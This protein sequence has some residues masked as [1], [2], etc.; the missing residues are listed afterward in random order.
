[1]LDPRLP[2]A[3]FGDGFQC[4][5]RQGPVFR[6]DENTGIELYDFLLEPTS[7]MREHFPFIRQK[8]DVLG[9]LWM[10]YRKTDVHALRIDPVFG[11]YL[12]T[13]TFSGEQTEFMNRERG[14]TEKINQQQQ[15]IYANRAH[16]AA[17]MEENSM[18]KMHINRYLSDIAGVF[19]NL[20]STVRVREEEEND[21]NIPN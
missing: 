18:M 13:C 16:A 12:I 5:I 7:E 11:R 8:L 15:V 9:R 17:L 10:T 3:W 2:L 14:Y 4:L 19:G 1:M 20:R 21:T 6:I